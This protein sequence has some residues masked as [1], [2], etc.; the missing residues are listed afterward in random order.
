MWPLPLIADGHDFGVY[1]FQLWTF[2][3]S[4]P[5][6]GPA[7]PAW[8]QLI[9]NVEEPKHRAEPQPFSAHHRAHYLNTVNEYTYMCHQYHKFVRLNQKIKNN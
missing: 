7:N 6:T 9:L 1:F 2:G 3:S 8:V 4:E 5:G